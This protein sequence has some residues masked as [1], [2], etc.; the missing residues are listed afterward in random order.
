LQLLNISKQKAEEP[1]AGGS[2][3]ILATLEAE[4]GRIAVRG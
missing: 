3:V 2:H 1:G 4:I